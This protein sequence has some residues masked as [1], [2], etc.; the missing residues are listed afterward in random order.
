LVVSAASRQVRIGIFRDESRDN[1]AADGTYGW[2]FAINLI[3]KQSA[4]LCYVF[5]LRVDR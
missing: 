1:A 3:D 4:K 2:E 5:G